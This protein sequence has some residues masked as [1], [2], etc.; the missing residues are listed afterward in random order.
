M[1]VEGQNDELLEGLL[2]KVKI[3]KDVSQ[4]CPIRD[5]LYA[6]V[7]LELRC[8]ERICA[9]VSDYSRYRE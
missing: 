2:G 8:S 9:D 7:T 5:F 1:A 4:T 3:L 6:S